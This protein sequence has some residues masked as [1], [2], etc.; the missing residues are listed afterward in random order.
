MRPELDYISRSQQAGRNQEPT[1]A[2]KHDH[3]KQP[4]MNKFAAIAIK[5][6]V[7]T[8]PRMMGNDNHRCRQ[9]NLVKP[10]PFKGYRRKPVKNSPSPDR[11]HDKSTKFRNAGIYPDAEISTITVSSPSD[12]S[13]HFA[14]LVRVLRIQFADVPHGTF[15]LKQ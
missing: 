15:W 8:P 5:R 1:Y 11:Q 6:V 12:A 4:E 10:G 7:N 2:K 9:P 14:G 13:L 3:G